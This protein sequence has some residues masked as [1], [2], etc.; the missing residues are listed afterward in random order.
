MAEVVPSAVPCVV[1]WAKAT[2]AI[3]TIVSGRVSSSLPIRDDQ[4]TYPWLKVTRIIGTP[5]MPEIPIDRAR[6]QFDALGGL[7]A[8]GLPNWE[9]ADLLVRTLE[10]EI[11]EFSGNFPVVAES[12]VIAEM[13]GLEGIQQLTDPDDGGARFWMDA[14]V[15]VR[16]SV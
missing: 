12:A 1:A 8:N 5:V 14:I 9:Q 4:I 15:L 7:T 16:R 3:D 13:V 11:R 2:P 10:A 6:V